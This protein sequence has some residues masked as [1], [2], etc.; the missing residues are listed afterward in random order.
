MRQTATFTVPTQ[1]RVKLNQ[2]LENHSPVCVLDS[3]THTGQCYPEGIEYDLIAAAGEI[4]SIA[5]NQQPF[6]ALDAFHEAQKDW[7]FGYFSYDLKNHLEALTSEKEDVIQAPEMQFFCPETVIFVKEG[8]LTIASLGKEPELVF[9]EIDQTIVHTDALQLSVKPHPRISHAQYIR[10][11]LSL[12]HHIQIGDIYE[13]NF[14]Q[15]FLADV[16]ISAPLKLWNNLI[17]HSPTPFSAYFQ[18]NHIHLMCASPERY[19]KK[20]GDQLLSQPIKGTAKRGSTADEDELIKKELQSSVKERA[21]NVMIVDLVRNDLSKVA[22]KNS[23]QVNELCGIYTFPQVHQQIST[24]SAQMKKNLP[25]SDAFKSTFPMGSMT[26]APKVRAM[27]L[28]EQYESYK[29]GLY[30]GAVG[31]ITPEGDFDFNVIIRSMIYNSSAEQ[32]SFSVG[33]A[34][35]SKSNPEHEY[36][37]SLLKAKAIREVLSR[38]DKH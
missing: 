7:L 27:E 20:I 19:L 16:N 30:S 12:K 8:S 5:P 22:S 24:V 25:L 35:T 23:V 18:Y 29:R 13:V 33:G 38:L 32:L 6:E 37:E 36:E 9:K 11:L 34:I 28:I 10:A 1:F 2:W 21:E 3:N 26:G 4:A 15:E 31:Y 17:E 14:C